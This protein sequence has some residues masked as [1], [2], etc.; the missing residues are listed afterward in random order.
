MFDLNL[1]LKPSGLSPNCISA[2]A[3]DYGKV[4]LLSGETI[5]GAAK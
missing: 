3:C 5:H 1:L 4:V 2:A